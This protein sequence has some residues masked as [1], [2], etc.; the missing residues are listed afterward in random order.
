[1]APEVVEILDWQLLVLPA[2]V[3]GL[4]SLEWYAVPDGRQT[5]GQHVRGSGWPV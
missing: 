2:G 5:T 3:F 1:M 4:P